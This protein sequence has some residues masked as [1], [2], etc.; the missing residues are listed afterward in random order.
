[1]KR[2]PGSWARVCGLLRGIALAILATGFESAHAQMPAE[3]S[4]QY[5]ELES[6]LNNRNHFQQVAATTYRREALILAEDRDPAD[7]VLRRTTALL[8]ILR[9]LPST[10]Q[11]ESLARE[12]GQLQ[13]RNRLIDPA[14][15]EARRALF[16]DACR[17]RRLIAFSNPLLNFSEILFIKR[18]RALYDHMCDQYYGMAAAPGGGLYVLSDAFGPDPQVRDVLENSVVAAPGRLAGQA[19]RGGPLGPATVSFDGMGNR[20][21]TEGQGGTFLSPDLAYDGRTILFAYV[22]NTGD[23]RHRHHVDPRQGHWAEGRCYHVFSVNV[24]GSELRQLTDGTWNDFDPCW[25]PNGR[26]AFISERRGGY[27]RCG[28]VCPTYTLFDMA[29]DGGDINCLSFHETNEWHPSVSN[30]GLLLWTRW[31]YIDRHGCAAHMPWVTTLDGRDP[32]AVHGNFSTRAARPDMEVDC[33]AIPDSSRLVAT[34]APHHGQAYG[35]LVIIDPNQLDDDAMSPVRRITPEAGFPETQGGGQVYGTP[36]PLSEDFYLCVY[37]AGMQPGAGQQ[38]GPLL[39]GNYGIYLVDAWGNRELIYRDPDISCLSPMPLRPRPMP[40][41]APEL[42]TRGPGTNPATRAEETAAAVSPS[43]TVSV[44]NVYEALKPWPAGTK[45]TALRV[46]QVFPMS[47]PSGAPPHETGVRVTTAGDSMVPVRHVLGTAPVEE[48]GSA[49][50]SVPANKEL[51]FQALNEQGLA[52]QSMRSATQVRQG[53]RLVCAGC[54]VP[55]HRVSAPSQIVPLALRRAPSA[56]SPDVDGSRP[57]SYPRLVQP[58]LD[59]HCVK[60]HADNPDK[61]PNLARDPIVRNWYASYDNLVHKFGFYDYRDPYRTTPGQFGALA[62]RLYQLLQAG[63]YDVRLPAEDLHRLTL[64]L[65]CASMFYGVYEKDEGAAQLRG[66]VAY[67]T[68]E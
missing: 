11:L 44:V 60:C 62:S 43:G 47:V 42:A 17:V 40:R 59:R 18:H 56:L 19:L 38:G 27:L 63:H 54:H 26:I 2:F 28:R 7:V 61:A 21:G 50:F 52:V 67:P 29:A 20:Q 3:W 49:F 36:W 4:N 24:D 12:L 14:D 32:R 31:D 15:R 37:D 45:I 66:E 41:V 34:A 39:R 8:E 30:E 58:V 22:E 53:E 13:E 16:A 65:D 57:F 35:S 55:R 10:D 9:R 68:L 46:L 33:R 64:W 5:A 1:M 6:S 51:F 23:M 48:D 25:L